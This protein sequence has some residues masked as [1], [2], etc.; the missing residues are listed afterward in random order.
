MI[1]YKNCPVCNS[2]DFNTIFSAKDYTVSG[3]TFAIAACRNCSLRFTQDIPSSENIGKYYASEKY[4]SHSDTQSGFINKVYHFIR[5]KTLSDKKE[6]IKDNTGKQ[7][8][9][10]LDV[11]CG[12]GAFLHVMKQG[13]W[14]CTGI[15]PDE[16]ARNKAAALY[17]IRPLGAEELYRLP[18]Q[19]FDAIT[20]WH[21]LEHVH[22]LQRYVGRLR[23]LLSPAG[24]LFIAVPNYTSYDA[25]HFGQY[26]AAYDVPRHLYHFSPAAM[27]ALLEK[28]GLVIK[29]MKPMWFD[30]FYVSM[31]SEK[32]KNGGNIFRAFFTGLI[33]NWKTILQKDRCSSLIYIISRA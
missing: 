10:I 17:G 22:E 6:L 11:G 13:G 14:E 21:V 25:E 2:D 29:H 8:G 27:K 19:T 4:I 33:S 23:D 15:E 32:Y 18:E 3:E 30:S 20:L 28:H 16:S 1:S 26:W 9:K 12:T 31:L 5:K 24:K 7:S